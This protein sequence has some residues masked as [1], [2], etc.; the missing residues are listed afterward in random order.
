MGYKLPEASIK[1]AIRHIC[2][3]GDT[4]VF[5]HLP[6]LAFLRDKEGEVIS[7]VQAIDLDAYN[8]GGAV[9]SLGPKSRY[10]FRIVHQL[11]ILDTVT[12]LASVIAVGDRIE[13]YR[14]PVNDITAFS[15][16]FSPDDTGNLFRPKHTYRDW[17]TAQDKHLKNSLKIKHVV[18]TDISD[19][20]ARINFHRLENLLDVVAPNDGAGRYIK[21]HIKAIRAKQSFGLPVGGT[22]ARLLAEL[23]LCDVDNALI[24]NG[25][26]F[27][28]FVDD[29]RVFLSFDQDPYDCLAFMAE[30]LGI[31]EGLSLNVAKTVVHSRV[32]YAARLKEQLTEVHDEAE[33]AAL[34]SLSSHLYFDGE[35]DLE[36]LEA[37]K[38][39]NLLGFLQEEVGK[40]FYDMG[41][42][43]IIFRALKIAKPKDAIEFISS[44]F[45]ELVV[46]AKEMVLLMQVLEK[47]NPHCFDDLADTAI[48]A[49][50]S[51]PASSIQLVKTWLLE[52]FVRGIIPLNAK[53]IKKIEH[54]SSLIDR[55]QLH[56]IR[57]RSGNLSYFRMNKTAFSQMA[58][59]E[60]SSFICGAACLPK[61]EYENWLPV[62]K[63]VF[64]SPLVGLYIKW[65]EQERPTMFKTL[66]FAAEE[67][68]E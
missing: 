31:N 30:Q 66:S 57:G 42:I 62:A 17:L 5:P 48:D 3:Y 26:V 14:R 46:F 37:L 40:A 7:A 52:L 36:E 23:V 65:A 50:L 9:E 21:K 68:Q 53:Q 4:D 54:L 1:S 43:K 47:D 67:P 20:Y 35:P 28:R 56:I 45:A 18:A 22:A 32:E 19:F 34:E 24:D 29:Y 39:M 25:F 15:Y 13:K 49:I 27:S 16:R 59:S 63:P 12:L 61:D 2:K 58:T 10:G 6:E 55:R 38:N 44:N 41:R 11:T 33:G 8:P 51:P 60:Q 64:N